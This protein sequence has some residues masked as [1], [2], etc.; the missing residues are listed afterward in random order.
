MM[1]L[2]GFVQEGRQR[3]VNWVEGAWKDIIQMGILVEDWNDARKKG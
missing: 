2:S 3:K 1:P